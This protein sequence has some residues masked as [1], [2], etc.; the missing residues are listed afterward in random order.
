[1]SAVDHDLVVIGAGSGGLASALRAARHG[2]RVALLEPAAVGGTCVNVGCVPKKVMWEA[3]SLAAQLPRARHFGLQVPDTPA[4]D[5]AQLVTARQAYIARIHASYQRQFNSTGVE[6]INQR[7]HLLGDGQ[8]GLA[9]G[10]T[11]RARHIV[12]ATGARPRRPDMPGAEHLQVSDDV[13]AW[14]ALPQRVAIIGGGYIG[15]ELAGL[16]QG[17]GSQVHLLVRGQRQLDG[18]DAELASQ[19]AEVMAGHGVQLH[20]QATVSAVA[21]QPGAL[22]LVGDNLPGGRFDAVVA[23]TGRQPN[24]DGLGLSAAG[25]ACTAKGFIQADADTLAT[26]AAGIWAVG[27]VT[28]QLALTPMAVAQG[29]RLADALFGPGAGPAIDPARVPSVVFSHPPLGKVG[30]DEATARQQHAQVS[31]YRANFLSLA[32][33]AGGGRQRHLFKVVCAGPE[34]TVVGIHLLGEGCDEMLQGFAVALQCGARWA[35]FRQT[36][37]IHPTSAEEVVLAR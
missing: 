7:G 22:E 10:R 14:D 3:A 9:D 27:D 28:G 12:L 17:L 30:L 29:R 24:V 21:G 23:A 36:L 16:L 33:G 13:F 32:E 15:V 5:W 1:M 26:S 25:V 35:H 34:E 19:L 18:F 20:W 37:P 31:V 6:Q 8:V 2:A 11:L 4:L